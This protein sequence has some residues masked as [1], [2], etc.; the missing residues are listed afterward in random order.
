MTNA[1]YHEGS[2]D[3]QAGLHYKRMNGRRVALVIE[4]EHFIIKWLIEILL[5]VPCNLCSITDKSM[6][7]KVLSLSRPEINYNYSFGIL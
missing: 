5:T 2:Q 7:K 6:T 3:Y 1:I 4:M